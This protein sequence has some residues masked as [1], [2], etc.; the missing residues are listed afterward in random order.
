MLTT[1]SFFDLNEFTHNDL[2]G[3]T[4]V[5]EVLKQLKTY[6]A[7]QNYPNYSRRLKTDVPLPETMVIAS[8]GLI[9]ASELEIE[10]GDATKEQIKVYK[11]GQ[12]LAGA[13]IIMAGA[14]LSGDQIK[15]E[16][17]ARI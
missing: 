9:P 12:I 8:S 11:E 4:Y 17:P 5:W 2:F 3:D 16:A 10:L 6:M 15:I 7:D 1:T 13:S 14:V